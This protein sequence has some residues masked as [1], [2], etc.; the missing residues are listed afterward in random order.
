M[1]LPYLF[2]F[3]CFLKYPFVREMGGNCIVHQ[4]GR[5]GWKHWKEPALELDVEA[6]W[7]FRLA[8]VNIKWIIAPK[9]SMTTLTKLYLLYDETHNC[10]S[11]WF[12]PH[13]WNIC[14][15]RTLSMT[16]FTIAP[17]WR[18]QTCSTMS[19][20]LNKDTT[21]LLWNNIRNKKIHI[22]AHNNVYRSWG[23]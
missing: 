19:E 8:N 4:C 3:V 11:E 15:Q 5:N 23:S 1:H 17:K 13:W 22:N 10:T 21:S 20:W 6:L 18:Q 9:M 16:V 12:H 2:F 14:S 7:F